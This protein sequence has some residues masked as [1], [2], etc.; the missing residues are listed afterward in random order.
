MYTNHIN[1]FKM[2]KLFMIFVV[3]EINSNQICQEGLYNCF[4]CNPTR[5][6]CAKCDKDIY[7]PDDKGGCKL[8]KKCIIGNNHYLECSEKT[9]LCSKCK[10]GYFYDGIGRCSYI[11]NFMESEIGKCIICKDNYILMWWNSN[12][13]KFEFKRF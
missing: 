6:L 8:F 9:N 5:N 12:K 1:A 13:K 2:L 11:D 3:L 4:S 7:E 10:E